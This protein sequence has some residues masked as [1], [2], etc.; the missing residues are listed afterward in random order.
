MADPHL[1]EK[2]RK[3]A[4]AEKPVTFPGQQDVD[5]ARAASDIASDQDAQI[6]AQTLSQ[7]LC[8]IANAMED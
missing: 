1:V 5:I 2:L 6:S 3:I 4:E 7:L 8:F